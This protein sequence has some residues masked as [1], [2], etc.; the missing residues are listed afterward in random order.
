MKLAICIFGCVTKEKYRNEIVKIQETWG[1]HT[2]A[3]PQ[4]TLTFFLGEERA[5]G[6]GFD[7]PEFV[8]LPGVGDDYQSASEKQNQGLHYLVE[9]G[10][11]DFI[12]VCGT[13]TFVNPYALERFLGYIDPEEPLYIGGH[14]NGRELMERRIP[15]FLGGAGF[16]LSRAAL[17]L[18]Y[19]RLATMT[20]DWN[21]YCDQYG[22]ADLRGACDL[23][24]GYHVDQLG[25]KFVK[26][27]QRFFECNYFGNIDISKHFDHCRWYG[28]CRETIRTE[29]IISCH[30]MSPM[31]VDNFVGILE[32][33]DWFKG[34]TSPS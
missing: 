14:D 11:Y 1:K 23:C 19:P 31:D 34:T 5:P 20:S 10:D 26:Y 12:F 15:F 6:A 24:I 29:R 28:C 3:S 33:N 22:Y 8:Y 17:R 7:G 2:S 27:H 4:I 16:V 9:Q 25:I 13:D 18:L 30:N 32:R 21:A